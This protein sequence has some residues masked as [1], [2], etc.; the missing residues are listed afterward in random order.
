MSTSS[1]NTRYTIATYIADIVGILLG[2]GWL[3]ILVF[4]AMSQYK[5]MAVV[6]GIFTVFVIIVA[7]W[8]EF[9]LFE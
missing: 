4:F 5:D 9:G 7:L 3:A 6:L 2:I 1:S 8:N